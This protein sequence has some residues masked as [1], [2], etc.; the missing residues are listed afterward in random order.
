M[1]DKERNYWYEML[2]S[3]TNIHIKKLLHILL[4][5]KINL[6]KIDIVF[7]TYSESYIE[8][9]SILVEAKINA[10]DNTYLSDEDYAIKKAEQIKNNH[11]NF[12]LK[13]APGPG[14]SKF[15]WNLTDI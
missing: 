7:D 15:N 3:M 1:G 12:S 8:S 13:T 5:E 4:I 11:L 6:R 2:P 10:N 14:G 9:I